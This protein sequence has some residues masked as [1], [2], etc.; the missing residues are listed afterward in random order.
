MSG[1]LARLGERRLSSPR[2]PMESSIRGISRA[3]YSLFTSTTAGLLLS[4]DGPRCDV[5][6]WRPPPRGTRSLLQGV[7]SSATGGPAAGARCPG[8]V[9]PP[10]SNVPSVARQRA[11]R[12]RQM[13]DGRLPRVAPSE[14]RSLG[15][16]AL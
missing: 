16:L 11:P 6:P 7:A 3:L 4:P 1:G 2:S 14:A 15:S 5:I 12:P 10:P 8:D 9:T 13:F